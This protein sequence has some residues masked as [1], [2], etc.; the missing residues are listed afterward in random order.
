MANEPAA[1]DRSFEQFRNY[2]RLLA[3]LQLDPR[4][5]GKLDPSDVVQHTL[6]KAHASREQFRGLS[7]AEQAAWLRKILANHLADEVRKFGQNRAQV[8]LECSLEAELQQSSARLETWLAGDASSPSQQAVRQEE[9]LQLAEALAALPDDQRRAIELHH[10]IGFTV[11]EVG[12]ELGRTRAAVAG[13]LRRAL[14]SLRAR[15]EENESWSP[16][17]PPASHENSSSTS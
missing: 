14:S 10:L 17:L 1:N 2:L 13:L 9:L 7:M 6:L 15:L 3:R 12:Q 8:N 11:A 16:S 4:L 5:K